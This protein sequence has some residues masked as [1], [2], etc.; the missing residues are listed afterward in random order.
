MFWVT[1]SPHELV[2]NRQHTPKP[3]VGKIFNS[4]NKNIR[5]STWAPPRRIRPRSR[6]PCSSWRTPDTGPLCCWRC[7]GSWGLL[8]SMSW[9]LSHP[10]TRRW[11]TWRWWRRRGSSCSPCPRCPGWRGWRGWPAPAGSHTSACWVTK[12]G[13]GQGHTAWQAHSQTAWSHSLIVVTG[14]TQL[15][16]LIAYSWVT[17][18]ALTKQKFV[19]GCTSQFLEAKLNYW[20]ECSSFSTELW[21]L[22]IGSNVTWSDYRYSTSAVTPCTLRNQVS[23]PWQ[24]GHKT[25]QVRGDLAAALLFRWWPCSMF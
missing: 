20:Y 17:N 14:V 5:V 21:I 15:G 23:Q 11:R 10:D 2:K 25:P 12:L 6:P 4:P 16:M 13:P 22:W 8:L 1:V 19:P 18:K 24:P 9:W 7:L 3:F